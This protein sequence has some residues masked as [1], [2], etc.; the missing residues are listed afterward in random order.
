M[1]KK[2]H[3]LKT[4]IVKGN[5][6]FPLDMLRY[7][8]CWPKDSRDA[9]DIQRSF[10]PM[11]GEIRVELECACANP[12]GAPTIGRWESFGWKVVSMSSL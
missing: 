2:T 4:F 6:P 9:L 7:D 3:F 11:Q 5:L 1:T 10:D 12:H 8:S